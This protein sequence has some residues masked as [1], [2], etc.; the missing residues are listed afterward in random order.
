M[1]RPKI[2]RN[3]TFDPLKYSHINEDTPIEEWIKEFL[4]RNKEFQYDYRKLTKVCTEKPHLYAALLSNL[5]QKYTNGLSFNPDYY[6]P[7]VERHESE[8]KVPAPKK[9]S[10]S[11]KHAQ[12]EPARIFNND[13]LKDKGNAE[14][15]KFSI[16][17]KPSAF[18]VLNGET[19]RTKL[20]ERV[21]DKINKEG[22]FSQKDFRVSY[23]ED[24]ISENDSNH[25]M[26][27]LLGHSDNNGNFTCGNRVLLA[28][29]PNMKQRDVLNTVRDIYSKI[30]DNKKMTRRRCKEW[31]RYLMI[32]D[33]VTN[34]KLSFAQ[35]S[36]EMNTHS[37]SSDKAP[38]EN[39]IG[40]N[41]K[42]AC[43]LINNAC[44]HF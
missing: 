15:Y 44:K 32:Y 5:S 20:Q 7:D 42:I 16:T 21:G 40:E 6:A 34:M 9:I 11:K 26:R 29:N 25:V 43:D 41:Y 38:D 14:F 28:F 39:I 35:I 23:K 17:I 10:K 18:I 27:Y 2:R 33:M 31:K 22:L 36:D 12:A 1:A 4:V 3:V 37:D 13:K 19:N 30:I 24:V 8:D